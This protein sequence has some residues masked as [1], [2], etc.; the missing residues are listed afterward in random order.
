MPLLTD[1]GGGPSLL[2]DAEHR[3]SQLTTERGRRMGRRLMVTGAAVVA[4]VLLGAMG[5]FACT[6]LATLNL[7]ASNVPSGSSVDVTGSSFAEVGEGVQ[8]VQIR[9]NATD[10]PVLAE[11]EPGTAGEF[12]TEI[13]V[14]EDA[15]PGHYTLV[16]TQL[17]GE[18]GHGLDTGEADA[19]P[20]FGTPARASLAV[21]S[22]GSPTAIDPVGAP[23]AMPPD[24]GTGLFA[25]SALLAL[26][27]LGLFG[28]ATAVFTRELRSRRR[29]APATSPAGGSRAG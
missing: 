23:A 15:Q 20:V 21:G 28:T 27:A 11:A 24:S 5:A 13:E 29:S 6:N 1:A 19:A 9:W 10:G 7:G 25:L 17:A 2:P 4:L 3:G 8:P 22:P 14:P 26:V 12:V 18:P 16:A